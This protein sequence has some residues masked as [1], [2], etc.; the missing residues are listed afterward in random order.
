MN[1][2]QRLRT[3][4]AR[5]HP[6]ATLVEQRLPSGNVW[7]DIHLNDVLFEIQY[8]PRN[9]YG[10]SEIRPPGP[11]GYGLGPDRHFSNFPDTLGHL[12][13]L[14]SRE[15]RHSNGRVTRPKP[16]RRRARQAMTVAAAK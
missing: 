4:L 2:V 6:G 9:G 10:V 13:R 8:Q 14:L 5:K 15:E 3:L 16:P 12:E 7:V 11:D 1:F